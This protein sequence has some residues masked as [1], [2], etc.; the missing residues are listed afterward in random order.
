M[1]VPVNTCN[2][3]YDELTYVNQQ[4]YTDKCGSVALDN[5]YIKKVGSSNIETRTLKCNIPGINNTSTIITYSYK[6]KDNNNIYLVPAFTGLGAPF[7]GKSLMT[8][9]ES[10]FCNSFPL[11]SKILSS[12]PTSAGS[13]S[14]KH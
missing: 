5:E 4:F 9:T 3:S 11:L 10:P 12:L 1:S 8:T 13:N 14:W 7:T 2:F 6:D